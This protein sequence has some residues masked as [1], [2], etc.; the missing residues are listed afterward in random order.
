MERGAANA[1]SYAR[2][3]GAGGR[4]DAAEE[5]AKPRQQDDAI[6]AGGGYCENAISTGTTAFMLPRF[7]VQTHI[8]SVSPSSFSR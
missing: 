7:F 1:G 8:F 2:V 5:G 6:P 3:S 4:T